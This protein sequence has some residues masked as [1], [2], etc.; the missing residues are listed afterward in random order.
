MHYTELQVTTNFSFL[1]GASHPE[2]LVERAAALGYSSIAVTDRNT[3]AGMVRAHVAAKKKGIRLVVGCRLDLVNGPSLLVYPTNKVA[4][5]GLCALLTKGNLRTE[6]GDCKIDK[7][8]VFGLTSD[9]RFI[10]LPPDSLAEGFD[11]EPSFV[12]SLKQFKEAFGG[13]LSLAAT[14]RYNGDDGKQLHRLTQLSQALHIP[15]VATND[16]HYHNPERRQLQDVLT[17][18]REGCTIQAAG[19]RLLPNAERY[20]KGTQEMKRL[21]R[22]YPQAIERTALIWKIQTN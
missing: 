16:V 2:E 12:E 9:S 15:L 1:R 17:C 13:N 22:Q 20:L 8:D 3:M 4:Y 6:K 14:R 7:D 11:F 21:F 10:A 19:Y 18:V 5:A